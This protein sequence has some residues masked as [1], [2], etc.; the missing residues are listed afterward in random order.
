VRGRF[1]KLKKQVRKLDDRSTM[2]DYHAVRRGA[3][4]LRYALECGARMFGKPADELLRALRRLQDCLG[5]QQDAHTAK[6]RLAAIVADPGSQLPADT[7]FLMG[8]LAEHHLKQAARAR[9]NLA[10]SWRKVR[11]RRWKALGAKMQEVR[12][13]SLPSA[14]VTAPAGTGTADPPIPAAAPELTPVFAPRTLKH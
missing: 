4:Q 8:R 2:E 14:A 10:R 9:K 6:N 13:N 12:E 5:A 1:K 11:G 3:K 7:L